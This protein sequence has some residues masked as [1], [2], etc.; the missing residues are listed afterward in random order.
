MR[1]A[2]GE[3]FIHVPETTPTE[4]SHEFGHTFFAHKGDWRVTLGADQHTVSADADV[5]WLWIPAGVP[6]SAE[7][8][9]EGAR[10]MCVFNREAGMYT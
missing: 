5:C 1:Y 9:T 3:Q 10:M 8:L 6:H 7:P 4:H 2:S